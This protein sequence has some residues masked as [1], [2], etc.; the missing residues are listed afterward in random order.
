MTKPVTSGEP[1]DIASR[2]E[3]FV[4]DWL[5]ERMDGVSLI[6]HH[7]VPREVAIWFDRPWEGTCS[8]LPAT[9][10]DGDRYRMW[11]RGCWSR[12]AEA[13]PNR[14]VYPGQCLGYAESED[15]IH[16]D[17][18][19]LG[20]F[21]FDGSTDNNVLFFGALESGLA[22]EVCVFKDGNPAAPD[23]ERYKAIGRG[24]KTDDRASLRGLVSPDGLHWKVVER[25]PILVAPKDNWPLFDSHSVAFWDSV[26]GQYVAYMRG[27][28]EPGVR[29]IRRSVSEDFREWTQ[30][31]FI[32]PYPGP[33]GSDGSLQEQLYHNACTPY[34]R[35]PHIYLMFPPR[36]IGGDRTFHYEEWKANGLSETVFMTSRD[37]ANWDRR[38]MEAFMRPGPDPDSW[39]GHMGRYLGVG[40]VPT[41]PAEM[42]V[43]FLEHL[44]RP[45]VHLRRGT[46]RIDGFVSVNAPFS[47][48]E[49]VT[50]PL[51]F[52]GGELVVNYASSVAGSLRVEIQDAEGHPID[53]YG[54]DE[55]IPIYGDEIDRVVA[56]EKGSD[57]GALSG[58]PVRLRF[59]MKDAD[60][61]SLR[62]L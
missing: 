27:L 5:I 6:L 47:G 16:W 41:G 14:F 44:H 13:A 20:I 52:E 22:R 2:L 51:T 3:L 15:G 37:G 35:A 48:G 10:K 25:D 33:L 32:Q 54:L 9:I 40:V 55:T 31:E 23:S 18:P 42:S 11:Y 50:R 24:F 8:G 49:L 45:S 34:Y 61:F 4:D 43:Y 36:M 19:S 21:E 62:F 1:R 39:Y 7:P 28:I 57:V 58:K 56:W 60:L 38:F 12:G 17:K 59:A 30:P 29:H 46:L 26:R 53:G